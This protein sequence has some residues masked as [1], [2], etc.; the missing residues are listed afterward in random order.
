MWSVW[1]VFCDC[2]FH[3]V[4][5][6]MDK[7]ERLMEASWWKRL[8]EKL[9]LVLMGGVLF[10]SVL[11]SHSIVSDSL[12][13]HEF[14]HAKP[15]CPSPTP[16]VHS[17]SRPLNRWCHPAIS[18]SVIPLSSRLQFFLASG[19]FPMSQSFTSVGQSTGASASASAFPMKSWIGSRN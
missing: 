8:K 3:S 7:D 13:P 11:I 5:P 9:G 1:S 17:N 2:D 12:R 18:S 19:S 16:G 4:C 14:Q 6:L 10:S 15:P